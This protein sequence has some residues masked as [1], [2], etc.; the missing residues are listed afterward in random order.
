[1]R[2]SKEQDKQTEWTPID[3]VECHTNQQDELARLTNQLLQTIANN[4]SVPTH[5]TK[6][7]AEVDLQAYP[8][9]VVDRAVYRWRKMY[10]LDKVTVYYSANEPCSMT[11]QWYTNK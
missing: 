7:I 9:I 1:M 11:L 2:Y 5:G 4:V 3:M 6:R 10:P 8:G